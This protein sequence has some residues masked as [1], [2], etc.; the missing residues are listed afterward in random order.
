MFAPDALDSEST[1]LDSSPSLETLTS[2]NRCALWSSLNLFVACEIPDTAWVSTGWLHCQIFMWVYSVV[3]AVVGSEIQWQ[4]QWQRIG[5]NTPW[6]T[7]VTVM[8]KGLSPLTHS[9]THLP[10]AETRKE[11]DQLSIMLSARLNPE[12]APSRRSQSRYPYSTTHW[13]YPRRSTVTN[14]PLLF[15]GKEQ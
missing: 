15:T 9:H 11:I 2:L 13:Q 8:Q 14:S 10:L 7:R 12:E 1:C 6:V 5:T 4:W 3:V